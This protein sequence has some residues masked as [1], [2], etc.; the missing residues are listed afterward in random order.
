MV[1][2][3]LKVLVLAAAN[4]EK[5][6]NL[7]LATVH[8]VRLLSYYREKIVCWWRYQFEYVLEEGRCSCCFSYGAIV[9]CQ[10]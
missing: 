2:L 10:R 3:I 6:G 9:L 5:I 1:G 8:I 7:Y 4:M